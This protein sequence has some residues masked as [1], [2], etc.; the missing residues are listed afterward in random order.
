MSFGTAPI[1]V[2]SQHALYTAGFGE[3]CSIFK[4]GNLH[5]FDYEL[6]ALPATINQDVVRLDI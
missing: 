6:L 2:T 5:L 1:I 3:M 4:V